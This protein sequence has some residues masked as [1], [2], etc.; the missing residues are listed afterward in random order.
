[1]TNT[2]IRAFLHSA[3][4]LSLAIGLT[5]TAESGV[6]FAHA[7][8]SGVGTLVVETAKHAAASELMFEPAPFVQ[9]YEKA[10]AAEHMT[11]G[12]ML[13]VLGFFFHA[14]LRARDERPVHIT[15]KPSK[16]RRK[17]VAWFWMEIRV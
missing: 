8:V 17:Q 16:K 12:I 7:T 3:T 4:V 13:I 6:D 11:L 5:M 9:A 14:L 15:V 1:M 2:R 10:H